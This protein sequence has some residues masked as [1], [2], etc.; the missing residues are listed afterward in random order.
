MQELLRHTN[1]QITADSDTQAIGPVRREAGARRLETFLPEA[2][3]EME[4]P[5]RKR[6]CSWDSKGPPNEPCGEREKMVGTW[7]LEPQT[8]TVSR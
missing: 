1:S 6:N 7:G 8:S 4:E 5:E 2:V 3:K